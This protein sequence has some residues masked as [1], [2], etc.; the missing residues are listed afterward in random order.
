MLLTLCNY[1]VV[2][3]RDTLRHQSGL[4]YVTLFIKWLVQKIAIELGRID[5]FWG[6]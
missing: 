2:V 4:R 1:C 5:Q 3:N 6:N